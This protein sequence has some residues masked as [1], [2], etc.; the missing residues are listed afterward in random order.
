MNL[1]L[2]ILIVAPLVG[3]LLFFVLPRRWPAVIGGLA[4]LIVGACLATE[5]TLYAFRLYNNIIVYNFGLALILDGLSH[6]MLVVIDGVA[7]FITLYSL[8]Y[9]SKYSENKRFFILFFLMLAGLHGLVLVSDLL[10]FYLFLEVSALAAYALVAYGSGKKELEATFKYFILGE[11][12]SIMI[13]LAIA[14]IHAT[15]GSTSM[16]EVARGYASLAPLTKAI[17]GCLLLGGIGTKTALFPFHWWLPDAHTAA[18]APVS[19][20]LS[21]VIIKILGIYALARILFNCLGASNQLLLVLGI[22]GG[23][24]ILYGGFLANRQNDMKR[25]MSYSS[26]S[27]IGYIVLGLSLASPLGIMGGLFHLFNHA[28]MKPL[29]F[30]VSG[31]V[32]YQTGTRNLTELGGLRQKMPVTSLGALAGSLAISGMPPFN[33]FWSKLFIIIACV[34]AG[35]LWLALAAVIGSLL[36]MAAFLKVMQLAFF[37]SLKDSLARLTEA[38]LTMT[39]AMAG[40]ALLTLL[41]GLFFPIIIEKLINPA[42]ITVLNGIGYSQMITGGR[43]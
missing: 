13:L 14:I 20:M 30:L 28:L 22:L 8:A 36:T 41:G 31:A 7:F 6:L 17:I 39:L 26:I 19:A 10:R 38:P 9:F 40:L 34:Q 23:L 11:L 43:L 27:Q 16:S 25:L 12:A 35:H 32:E 24:S 33:G 4:L 18:P 15:I 5:I 3:V 37:S 2:P 1:S 42:A 29:L 21:G